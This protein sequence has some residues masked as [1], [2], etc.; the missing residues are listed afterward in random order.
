MKYYLINSEE[1]YNEIRFHNASEWQSYMGFNPNLKTDWISPTLE[2]VYKGNIRKKF[3]ISTICNPLYTMSQ[4]AVDCLFNMIT[5][6]GIILPILSPKGY[7]FF[8]CTNI[9]NALITEQSDINYLGEEKKWISSIDNFTLSKDAIQGQDIF[10]IPE[11][12][13]RYTFFSENFKNLV[14]LFNLNG[15][16]FNRVEQIVIK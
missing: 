2:Y 10:R 11:A 12:G 8:Y 5:K 9:V 6:Y 3:D 14:E 4:H 16:H 13:Y 15:I 7:Y 1:G